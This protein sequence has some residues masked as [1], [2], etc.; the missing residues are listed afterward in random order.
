MDGRSG[1]SNPEIWFGCVTDYVWGFS[2]FLGDHI[3]SRSR[4]VGLIRTPLFVRSEC[5]QL[6][7]KVNGC[8]FSIAEVS[9]ARSF[10]PTLAFSRSVEAAMLA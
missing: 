10:N 7:K 1:P 8:H 6:N 5:D 3:L 9:R 2:D 4:T